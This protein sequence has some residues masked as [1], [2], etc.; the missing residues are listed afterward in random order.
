[1]ECVWTARMALTL[2]TLKMG[3]IIAPMRSEWLTCTST[4]PPLSAWNAPTACSTIPPP[5]NAKCAQPKIIMIVHRKSVLTVLVDG[6]TI[7]LQWSVP[8][9][10]IVK[11]MN[12]STRLMVN[13]WQTA[14]ILKKV[15]SGNKPTTHAWTAPDIKILRT[16]TTPPTIFAI[17][18][19]TEP[20]LNSTWLATNAQMPT[21]GGPTP[22]TVNAE[23]VPMVRCSVLSIISACYVLKEKNMIELE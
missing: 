16:T 17:H 2:G 9:A 11:D 8:S 6:Y 23:T 1:M 12:E 20:S 5:C 3:A 15:S 21:T 4:E 13:V 7:T 18:V 22:L 14:V 19:L 10:Q